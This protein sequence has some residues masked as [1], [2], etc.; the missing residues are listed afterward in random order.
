MLPGFVANDVGNLLGLDRRQLD[1]SRQARL[2]RN[3]NRHPIAQHGIARKELF[4]R[5]AYQ[6]VRIGPGLAQDFR[7]LDVVER[8]G[9]NADAIVVGTTP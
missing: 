6:F 5:V 3:R 4:Q 9:D 1:E 2:A 8:V 7:I